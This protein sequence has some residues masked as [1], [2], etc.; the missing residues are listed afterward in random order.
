[1]SLLLA[2]FVMIAAMSELRAG[3]RFDEVGSAV[4]DAFGFAP[5][6]GDAGEDTP[7][8]QT[9]LD[10]LKQ[11]GLQDR[12]FDP[13]EAD[14][15]ALLRACEI[16]ADRERLVI[17]VSGQTL[18]ETHSARLR[19]EGF[20]VIHRLADFLAGG[21][22]RLEVCGHNGDG[23]LPADAAFRDGLDLSYVRARAVVDALTRAGVE[24]E[25]L[26]ITAAGDQDPLASERSGA[27]SGLN[28]RIEIIVHA[29][30]S[31][32]RSESIAE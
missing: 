16:V 20:E 6:N 25:R 23:P 5:I 7:A 15:R 19:L 8:M 10:R 30:T 24:P 3:S 9:L 21:R 26:M 27:A 13:Q 11:A 12:S 29:D 18:F 1:M 4:R 17:R 14:D 32:S 31:A 2:V 28:R 22:S